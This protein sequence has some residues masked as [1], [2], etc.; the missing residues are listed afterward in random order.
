MGVQALLDADETALQLALEEGLADRLLEGN[1]VYT[2]WRLTPTAPA[3]CA[4]RSLSKPRS[5]TASYAAS[6]RRSRS[7]VRTVSLK[8]GIG[9]A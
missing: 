8:R 5:A 1:S 9:Q 6:R 4:M 3:R 2:V 7:S